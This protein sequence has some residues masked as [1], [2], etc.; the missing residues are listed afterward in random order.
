MSDSVSLARAAQLHASGNIQSARREAEAVLAADPD[1]IVAL[2]FAGV[3]HC[4]SG[5]PRRGADLLHRALDREPADL[6]TRTNLLQA[7]LDS[8]QLEE[9]EKVGAESST[10]TSPELFRARAAAA[11]QLGKIED[12]VRLLEKAVAHAPKDFAAWNNFG[13]ALNEAD[14]PDRAVKALERARALNPGAAV[15]HLNLGRALASA[16]RDEESC[17][18][19]ERAAQLDPND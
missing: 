10:M 4:Q 2:R 3:L 12:A 19:F 18:S 11:R 14:Q 17:Q 5:D 1:N 6:P 8:G 9:A 7:L 15:V 16:G 13:N